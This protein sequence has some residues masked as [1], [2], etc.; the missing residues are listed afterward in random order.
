M[1]Q[2]CFLGLLNLFV[3][4]AWYQSIASGPATPLMSPEVSLSPV[5]DETTAAIIS[6][7]GESM[8]G[9]AKPAQPGMGFAQSLFAAEASFLLNKRLCA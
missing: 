8:S 6:T 3:M 5:Q 2:I 1:S 7:N 9:A 4:C